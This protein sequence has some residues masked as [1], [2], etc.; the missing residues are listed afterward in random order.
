MELSN[1]GHF[2]NVDHDSPMNHTGR[3]TNRLTYEA[4]NNVIL[5][6]YT[7]IW[8]LNLNPYDCRVENLAVVTI[9]DRTRLKM[10]REFLNNSVDEMIKREPLIRTFMDPEE[11]FKL[12]KIPKRIFT[13]WKKRNNP[14]LGK[15]KKRS[16]QHD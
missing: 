14:E 3:T 8:H 15:Y 2:R 7:N 10:E 11:Y 6:L 1:Y 5:P 9:E 12:L 13:N 4:F 16:F